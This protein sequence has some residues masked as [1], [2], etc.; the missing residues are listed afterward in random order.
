MRAVSVSSL[1][2][3]VRINLLVFGPCSVS[4]GVCEAVRGLS[5]LALH[6]LLRVAMGL[7][8][9]AFFSLA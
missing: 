6:I 7:I 8:V 1:S 5:L 2:G 4:Y 9:G 3:Y